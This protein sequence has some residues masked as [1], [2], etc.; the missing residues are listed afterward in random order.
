MGRQ[1]DGRPQQL[2]WENWDGGFDPAQAT[3]GWMRATAPSG[4]ANFEG[5]V[6]WSGELGYGVRAPEGGQVLDAEQQAAKAS[7][8]SAG[9]GHDDHG[10]HDDDDAHGGHH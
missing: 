6:S 4:D 10:D 5:M 8:A 7:K 2:P 9:D 1:D 3:S